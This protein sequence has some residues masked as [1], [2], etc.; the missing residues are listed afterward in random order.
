MA[1]P[2]AR[3]E[4]R[5]LRLGPVRLL[6]VAAGAL[7]AAALALT[8]C[9]QRVDEAQA[10]L[11]RMALP[12]LNPEGSDIRITRLALAREG[13]G[14]R[15]D[16]TVTAPAIAGTSRAGTSRAGTNRAGPNRAG[17]VRAFAICRFDPVPFS[18]IEPRLAAIE[19]QDGP[20]SG[21]SVYLM[22]RFWLRSP[23]AYAADPGR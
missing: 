22:Q 13:P 12:A 19:T 17:P 1:D 23:E 9:G 11:C 3:P 7:L 15:I 21:A 5:A 18:E 14:I 10:R 2:T 20:V 16:Y 8:G 6:P 4:G